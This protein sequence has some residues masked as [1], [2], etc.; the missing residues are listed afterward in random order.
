[1]KGSH[2]HIF[3]QE[4]NRRSTQEGI[5]IRNLVRRY[6]GTAHLG[7]GSPD[8][9]K[10]QPIGQSGHGIRE[11]KT[12]PNGR[13]GNIVVCRIQ[14]R[15]PVSSGC[16]CKEQKSLI[17][18]FRRPEHRIYSGFRKTIAKVPG[19]RIVDGMEKGN[20]KPL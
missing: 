4:V 7:P 13:I 20:V 17:T 6:C 18:E 10:T 9:P 5:D 19:L 1:G 11:D 12:A 2:G 15:K 8:F 14:Y 16:S 3:S